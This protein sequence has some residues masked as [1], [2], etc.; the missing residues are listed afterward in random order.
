MLQ[1]D[2]AWKRILSSSLA[3]SGRFNNFFYLYTFH[4]R[5]FITILQLL[6]LKRETC[7]VHNNPLWIKF[8]C[9]IIRGIAIVIVTST[10]GI[11]Y[12]SSTSVEIIL[13]MK[14]WLSF[15]KFACYS[16]WTFRGLRSLFISKRKILLIYCCRSHLILR[17]LQWLMA[18]GQRIQKLVLF[19]MITSLFID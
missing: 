15:I 13:L 19:G 16:S 10:V 3:W 11:I 2:S 7:W 6:L 18:F 12:G 4:I 14:S 17:L 9:I 5:I 8:A 1:C